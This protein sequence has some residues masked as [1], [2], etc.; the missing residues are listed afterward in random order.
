MRISPELN[1]LIGNRLYSGSK[2]KNKPVVFLFHP[3]E[4]LTEKRDTSSLR[5]SK[6]FIGYLFSDI[7]RQRI[8]LKNLGKKKALFL[9]EEILKKPKKKNMNLLQLVI[10]G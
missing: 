2:E 4:V 3:T 1:S 10:L 5:R 7:L 9:H 6:S 8:K